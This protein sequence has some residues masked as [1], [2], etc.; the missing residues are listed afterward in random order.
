MIRLF[1]AAVAAVALLATAGCGGGGDAA[2]AAEIVSR[3]ASATA[4]VRRFHF[5]LDVQRVPRSVTGL[6]LTSAEGDVVVPD[7]ARADVAGTFA[8]VPITTRIVAVGANVWLKNPLSGRWEAV[9][10]STTPIALLDPSRG[11]LGVM[12]GITDPKDEGTEA[13]DGVT[14]RKLSGTASAAAVAPLAAVRPSDRDV[15]VTLWVGEDDH[16]LRRIEVSGAVADGEPDDAVRVVEISR[17]DE[18]VTIEAP[19]GAG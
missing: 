10:V 15:P 5:T 19:E 9:D 12:R 1:S 6:Q 4:A 16:L 3:S 11:V 17:F 18:P 7:R 8:G 14:L 13:V 2:S